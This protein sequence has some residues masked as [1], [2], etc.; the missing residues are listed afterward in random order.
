M[1]ELINFSKSY[2]HKME[3]AVNDV[4]FLA[5]DGEVTGLLGVNGSGKSTIIK[6]VTGQHF[7]TYGN[8]IISGKN[9][10]QI[11]VEKNP[12]SAKLCT[13]YVPEIT[14]LPPDMTVEKFLC[15]VGML[16]GFEKK[17]SDEKK[18]LEKAV[19]DVVKKCSLEEVLS[20]KIKT[21]S[22][23]FKQRVSFAQSLIHNPSVLILDEPITG[24]DPAQIIQMRNL[25]K[26]EA[27]TKT[28]LMSTHILQ[29]VHSL[30]D[31]IIIIDKG[32]LIAKGTEDEICRLA[33][34][35]D[36]ESAFLKLVDDSSS[37]DTHFVGE[38]K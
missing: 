32:R 2:S 14:A 27:K 25:I 18:S 9:G 13:G 3:P 17:T 26:E 22:K 33:G 24:L 35:S 31:K 11:D 29:E 8:I 5:K 10:E 20:K 34:T 15:Y 23:G 28:V 19:S 6:A 36:F 38:H 16:Y 7:P 30:C 21:L 4:S 37:T 1:I 12:E